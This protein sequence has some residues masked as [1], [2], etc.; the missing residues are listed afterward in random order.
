MNLKILIIAAVLSSTLNPALA[1]ADNKTDSMSGMKASE[2]SAPIQSRGE[3]T[4]IN[5]DKRKITLNHEPIP[6]L[7]WPRMTM[8]FPL[9]SGVSLE[10]FA[11]GDTVEF[12]LAPASKGQ[13]VTSIRKP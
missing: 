9:A 1:T 3:I 13:Q 2:S 6:E 10:G 7:N 12:T 5:A 8:G 11:I 4:K